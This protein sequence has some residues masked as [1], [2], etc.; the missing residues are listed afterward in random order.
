MESIKRRTHTCGELRSE[1]AGENVILHGWAD[2]VR[3]KGG[4]LFL[5]LRDRYGTV[6]ITLNDKNGN[7]VHDAPGPGAL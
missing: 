4:V 5:V 3:D 6:Q 2:S 1:H 7:L